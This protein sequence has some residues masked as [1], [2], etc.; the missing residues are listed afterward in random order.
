[1]KCCMK[2]LKNLAGQFIETVDEKLNA[3]KRK[4]E[5]LESREHDVK[6]EL[7]YAEQLSMKK[8]RK[9]VQNWLQEVGRTKTEVQNLEARVKEVSIFDHLTLRNS[10]DRHTTEVNQ[11][12]Q[13]GVFHGGL[14]LQVCDSRVPMVT[15]ELVGENFQKNKT[16]IWEKLMNDNIPSVRV[17]GM[18]GIGKTTLITHIHD[19]LL[20][21]PSSSVAWVT[22]SHNCRTLKLQDNIAN[23]LG[24]GSLDEKDERKR[25]AVLASV[26]RKK[27]NFVLIL[28][29]IWDPIK[30]DEVGI[31]A[32][33]IGLYPNK[34]SATF[35]S[36]IEEI[37]KS[38]VNEFA[39]LPL[40]IILAA[41]CVRGVDD[42][43]Q[44]NDA[45]EQMKNPSL[46]QDEL[47]FG[48]LFQELHNLEILDAISQ[49]KCLLSSL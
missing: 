7:E 32:N 19:Q 29:D 44:W 47:E 21:H 25:A 34:Y 12:I 6:V 42:I 17:F 14:T 4:L 1:M 26:L 3:L 38:L 33:E 24:L 11:L 23:A 20:G 15:T 37:G 28:D 27:K 8:P 43:C 31:P 46:G 2:S 5:Q 16:A 30:L 40:G 9:E 48:K 13:R 22:V 41:G 49:G 45:L 18:G 35:P 10:I 39:G 36:D